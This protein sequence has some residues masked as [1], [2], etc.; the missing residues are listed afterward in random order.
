M[1]IEA[2]KELMGAFETHDLTSFS[3]KCSEFELELKKETKKVI[4]SVQEEEPVKVAPVVESKPL[5]NKIVSQKVIKSPMVGT[6]Y[7]AQSPTDAPFVTLGSKIQKGDTVCVVEAMKLMNEVV[8]EFTGEVVE[9]LVKNEEMVEFD[10]PLFV[11][12]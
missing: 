2:I 5:E 9:I 3:L 7:T 10:Q 11:I 4:A 12:Q 8:S 6:F 1:E